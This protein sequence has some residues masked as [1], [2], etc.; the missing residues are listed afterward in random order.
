MNKT[1]K[2]KQTV[3]FSATIPQWIREISKKYFKEASFIDLVGTNSNQTPNLIEHQQLELS[4]PSQ[5]IIALSK[6]IRFYRNLKILVFADTK[7]ECAE[8][9]ASPIISLGFLFFPSRFVLELSI[10]G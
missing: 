8:L 6:F 7:L 5:R 1:P 2:E 10:N 3:L 4:L 9:A